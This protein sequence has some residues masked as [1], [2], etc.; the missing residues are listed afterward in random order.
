[1]YYKMSFWSV[2]DKIPIRQT[3]VSVFAENG[4][5]YSSGQKINFVI[6]PTISYFQPKESYLEFDVQIKGNPTAGGTQKP[7]RMTLDQQT[8]AQCL[9]RDIRIHSGGAGAVLLEEIQNYNTLVAL[10]YDYETNDVM[11]NKRALTEGSI[12]QDISIR[13]TQ[14]TTTGAGNNHGTQPYSQLFRFSEGEPI[15]EPGNGAANGGDFTDADM[16]KARVILPLHTGIFSNSKVFPALLTEGLRIEI[17][18]ESADRVIRVPDQINPFRHRNLGLQFHSTSGK[19]SE[20]DGAGRWTAVEAAGGAATATDSTQDIFITRRNNIIGV[21]NCGLVPGQKISL[22]RW[23]TCSFN[24]GDDMDL[25]KDA[26]VVQA[27][28]SADAIIDY[29]K[30]IPGTGDATA[31][32]GV[33]GLLQIRLTAAIRN[34]ATTNT[35]D[36]AGGLISAGS[37]WY[38][39][40]GSIQDSVSTTGIPAATTF[41]VNYNLSNVQM[42][43]QQIDMPGGYTNKLMGM[44]KGGGTMNY[45]FL[46]FTNYKYSQIKSDRVANIRLPLSQSRAKAILCV[47]TDSEVY[48]TRQRILGG[49]ATMGLTYPQVSATAVYPDVNIDTG[50]FTYVESLDG[51]GESEMSFGSGDLMNTSNRS[52][53]T[54]IWDEMTDYQFFYDGKLNPSRK[55]EC[56]KISGR[57]SIQQQP[58]IEL[59]KALAMSDI[60]PLSFKSFNSN[61]CI[62]RALALQDGCYDCR[63]KD[64]NLQVN[65]Q[66]TAEPMK[67]K[68]WHNYVAHLR[69]IEVKGDQISLQI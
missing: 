55:V 12:V 10:K 37:R 6:P 13:G 40:D 42:V 59:E 56:D 17:I 43:L 47:P 11:K 54:G 1:M 20:V 45:D 30:F 23:G 9:I 31:V 57:D 32:G 21:D 34:M 29:I 36:A 8:G 52:G 22:W 67:N 14:G 35:T 2:D 53:L 69:R 62:G 19:D 5:E 61:A 3:K 27:A 60:E 66:Q 15:A 7:C 63:G 26:P 4:L 39:C 41:Q 51:N 58:L 28:L 38:V 46:S 65:Y 24:K 18:L 25:T 48:T 50:S 64:F 16:T 49:S 33:Y 68:L 44:M